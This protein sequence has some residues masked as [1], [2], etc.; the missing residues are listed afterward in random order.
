M[1]SGQQHDAATGWVG[2]SR[3]GSFVAGLLA[4]LLAVLLTG[5]ILARFAM[6]KGIR[7]QL[8]GAAQP[9]RWYKPDPLIG[10]DFRSYEDVQRLNAP[11]LRRLGPLD[12]PK[13]TWLLFGNSFV[14]G[15]GN[16]ADTAE[17][18]LPDTRIFALRQYV[19]LPLRAAEAR[20]LASQGLRPSEIFFVM[21]PIDLVQIGKRPLSFIEVSGD[22]AI[23]TKL[24]WPDPPWASAVKASR[25]AT[26]AWVRSGRAAGDPTFD[27][28]RVS[29][30]PSP[31]VQQ[32]LSRI[33]NHLAETSRR[34]NV[35]VTIV[36]LSNRDQVFGR[37]GFG[38]QDTVQALAKQ[39]GIDFLDARRPFI[40][41]ADKL[42]L[43]V[44][45]WHFSDRGNRLLLQEL[46]NHANARAAKVAKG[47]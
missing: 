10:A 15:P 5:E 31:R 3:P 43:F 22:G 32:D 29:D 38:F 47:A 9:Q 20:Q 14:Q 17:R 26:I 1:N 12:L 30:T 21:L 34:Y 7:E 6:P 8:Q 23:G 18:L 28:R 33:F 13:P 45:D 25:L 19:D 41:A 24:R 4:A 27:A 40:E 16:L 37:A 11:M 46:I 2:R 44:P 36:T 42:S 39:A 35:P